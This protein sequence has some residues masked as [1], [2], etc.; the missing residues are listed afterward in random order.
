MKKLCRVLF[1]GL[2][3]ALY[4][5][6]FPVISLG[7]DAT[8]NF[9]LSVAVLWTVVCVIVGAVTM[10]ADGELRR[11]A[12]KWCSKWQN[13]L[14]AMFPV[15]ASLSVIWS[16][17]VLRGVL[18]AGMMWLVALSVW[19]MY[20][21]RDVL[22]ADGWR[23][24]FLQVFVAGTLIVCAWCIVQC[25]L[26]LV[27][28]P[29][30]CSLLC[31]GCVSKMFG[32]PHPN[33]FAIEPQFMGNLL[34]APAMIAGYMCL[35]KQNNKNYFGSHFL[36]SGILL[37]CFSVT[38]FLTFSRGAIYAFVVGMVFLTTFLLARE[39]KERKEVGKRLAGMW[40]MIILSFVVV[41]NVQGLM[42]AVGPTKDTY[43]DGVAKVLNH[44]SLGVIDVRGDDSPAPSA[45]AEE[46]EAPLSDETEENK[47]IFDGYVAESTDTRVRLTSDALL[48]WQSDV[49]NMTVGV[50]LGGAGTALYNAGLS[51]A[52][53]EI[54][55]NEYA[56]LLL[57][58]GAIGIA[59][60]MLLMV[61]VVRF[62]VKYGGEAA[63]LA[64][65]VAYGATLL[66]FSGLPNALQVYIMP[67]WVWL[68]FYNARRKKLVS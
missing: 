23:K 32:F 41:L 1:A 12:R 33:G 28:V 55:Q 9:E 2:P 60:F 7:G 51:P 45:D 25:V 30:E 49:K 40:G 37:F 8:M 48:V 20:I 47:A 54:V 63:I 10:L 65:L 44:L 24:R 53:K 6:Y 52:P 38:L 66:F 62:V 43:A 68:I 14:W 18:T 57:E 36:C 3:V 61:L 64:M 4:F 56:S 46:T 50:G 35:E 59:L 42:A 34:I 19:E 29:R 26:D 15:F 17:N 13:W 58:T 39:K 67:I 5:S 11:E 16:E 31:P 27:G 22:M 21:L